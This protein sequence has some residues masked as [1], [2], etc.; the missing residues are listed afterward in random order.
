VRRKEETGKGKCLPK[1]RSDRERRLHQS[2]PIGHE[3]CCG[4][5]V[6]TR[7][8]KGRERFKVLLSST[9][10]GLIDCMLS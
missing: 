1:L 4:K 7:K 10:N 8:G 2:V 9:Q 6:L 5:R 3:K